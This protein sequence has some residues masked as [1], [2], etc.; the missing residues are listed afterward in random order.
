MQAW[1]WVILMMPAVGAVAPV[2]TITGAVHKPA[3]VKRVWAIDRTSDKK[4]DA[5]FNRQTGQFTIR[6]L[7]LPAHYDCIVDLTSGARLEGVN[8]HVPHSDYEEEQPLAAEDIET[9]KTKVRGLNQFE[10]VVDILDVTGNIQ[11]AVVLLNK[12]RTKPFYESKPGEIIWRA[13]LWHFERPDETWVKTQDELF[14]VLYRE[15]LPKSVYDTK[16][17]TFDPGLG[18]LSLTSQQPRRELGVVRLPPKEP[19]IRLRGKQ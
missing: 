16:S 5:E 15:R 17:I 8:F 4:Y 10:N 7:P 6:G 1:V 2:G 13:E 12:L 18:G 9:I 19:G 3:L 14:G 11:H